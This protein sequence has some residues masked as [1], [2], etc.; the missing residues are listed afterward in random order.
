M[1]FSKL[2]YFNNEIA[3]I[4]INRTVNVNTWKKII[5]ITHIIINGIFSHIMSALVVFLTKTAVSVNSIDNSWLQN[6]VKYFYNVNIRYNAL[7]IVRHF[8]G[9]LCDK[10]Y[11]TLLSVLT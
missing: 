6:T 4:G 7:G 3:D 5:F 11:D 10:N 1:P 8:M 2:Q 9:A